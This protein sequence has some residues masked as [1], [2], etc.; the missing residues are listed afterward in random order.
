M[1][2]SDE[3]FTYV[4]E[5]KIQEFIQEFL[6]MSKM[7]ED[8]GF[9]YLDPDHWEFEIERFKKT[10]Q[11]EWNGEYKVPCTKLFYYLNEIFE[12]LVTKYADEMIE[13]GELEL[14]WDSEQNDFAYRKVKNGT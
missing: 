4:C 1:F 8:I 5:E 9:V 14:V 7:G 11:K 6:N 2:D 3:D 12:H 10:F 13:D